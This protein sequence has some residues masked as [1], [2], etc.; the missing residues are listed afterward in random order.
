M[1]I[2]ERIFELLDTKDGK[3]Q[4]GLAKQLGVNTNVISNWKARG[5][6]PP[7][8]QIVLISEYFDVS[9]Y[10]LLTG[11]NERTQNVNNGIDL[12]EDE[13]RVITKYRSLDLDGKDA[14][15]GVLLQEQRRVDLDRGLAQTS[16]G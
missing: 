3:T 8:K 11:E 7:A 15:R 6:D 13:L 9:A 10:F 5:S 16:A 1:T 4:A 12:S 2:C 14:V